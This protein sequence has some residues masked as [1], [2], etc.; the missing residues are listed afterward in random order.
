MIGIHLH[1]GGFM[2]LNEESK[3]RGL[4]GLLWALWKA[5]NVEGP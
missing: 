5:S 3:S 4:S 1:K 2:G